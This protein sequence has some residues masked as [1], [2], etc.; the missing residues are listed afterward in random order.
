M[1][2]LREESILNKSGKRRK[3]DRVFFHNLNPDFPVRIPTSNHSHY[4]DSIPHYGE[5]EGTYAQ[6]VMN[7]SD[8]DI[9]AAFDGEPDAYWNID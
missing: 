9:D 5:Y 2:I 6:D 8:E 1:E 7:F 3:D 4:E